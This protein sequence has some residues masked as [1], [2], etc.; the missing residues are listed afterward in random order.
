MAP[1]F[2]ILVVEDDEIIANL[3]SVM[4]RSVRITD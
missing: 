1:I 2:R 3:I 4:R